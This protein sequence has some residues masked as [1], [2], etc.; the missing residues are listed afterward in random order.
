MSGRSCFTDLLPEKPW[1]VPDCSASC[2]S[3]PG[4]I[5][6]AAS[7]AASSFA[8]TPRTWLTTCFAQS[9]YSCRRSSGQFAGG[10]LATSRRFVIL[11]ANFTSFAFPL[12]WAACSICKRL[13]ST[14]GS[15]LSSVTSKTIDLIA[16]PN[17]RSSSSG[18]VSVSSIV[19]C[20]SAAQITSTSVTPPS[21]VRIFA[22]EIG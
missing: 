20:R 2:H 8:F 9:K 22:S 4:R 11:S 7:N 14:F 21:F 19:S 10:L 1:S 16:W 15:A 3:F 17:S 5:S 13:R 18:V 12:A 6:Y